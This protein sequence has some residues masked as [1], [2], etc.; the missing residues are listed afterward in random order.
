MHNLFI[1][2]CYFSTYICIKLVIKVNVWF[3]PFRDLCH[4]SVHSLPVT[5]TSAMD[6]YSQII[7]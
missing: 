7:S 3:D 4:E 1:T 5:E 6:P 2:D